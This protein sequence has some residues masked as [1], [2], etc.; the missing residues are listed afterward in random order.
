MGKRGGR[1]PVRN[2]EGSANGGKS[3]PRRTTP[4]SSKLETSPLLGSGVRYSS[5]LREE[6]TE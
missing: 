1:R 2:G 4:G 6:R 5:A 3:F